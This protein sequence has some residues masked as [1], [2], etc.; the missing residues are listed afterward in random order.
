MKLTFNYFFA[1]QLLTS[2]DF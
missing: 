1:S 2:H